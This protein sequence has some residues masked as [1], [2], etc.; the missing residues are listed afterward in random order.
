[1]RLLLDELVDPQHLPGQIAYRFHAFKVP[2]LGGSLY[3]RDGE[4]ADLSGKVG[5]TQAWAF[6]LR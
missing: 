5:A 2:K 4:R 3:A 6:L 1:M